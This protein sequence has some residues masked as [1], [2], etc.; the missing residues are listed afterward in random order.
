LLYS[1]ALLFLAR[2]AD[3]DR[4]RQ[5][6]WCLF[7]TIMK[8]LSFPLRRQERT[9]DHGKSCQAQNDSGTKSSDE[10]NRRVCVNVNCRVWSTSVIVSCSSAFVPIPVHASSVRIRTH[11]CSYTRTCI[12]HTHIHIHKNA[13]MRIEAHV[14]F[15]NLE[16]APYMFC[17]R[18]RCITFGSFV[19]SPARET[20]VYDCP[21]VSCPYVIK[22]RYLRAVN[23]GTVRT[24][25]PR[26]YMSTSN[27]RG[28]VR[29][30]SGFQRPPCP[31]N[32]GQT[33]PHRFLFISLFGRVVAQC[34]LIFT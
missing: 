28:A 32:H 9:N 1:P 13:Y 5:A 24:R 30:G 8:G 25:H 15:C 14:V 10:V 18:L 19:R 31:S 34:D 12:P 21:A 26:N 27:W 17:Q 3:T 22:R 7:T 11:V 2:L 23:F 6:R 4:A 16:L 29:L 20:S 33:Q